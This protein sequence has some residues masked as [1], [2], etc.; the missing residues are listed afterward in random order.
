M[1]GD[2]VGAAAVIGGGI[3]GI[4]SALDLA[5]SGIKVYLI[6]SGPSIGGTMSQLDK[7]FPTMD[8]A[9]CTLSPKLV[10]AERHPNIE[11]MTYCDL[12]GISGEEG[13][14]TVTVNKKARYV[15][16]TKCIGCEICFAK[17]PVKVPDEYNELLG[18]HKAIY[19]PF[20]QAVPKIAVIDAERCL[21]LTKGKCGNCAKACEAGAIDYEQKDKQ[22]DIPVGAIILTTGFK[23]FDAAKLEQYHVE[24]TKVI[25]SMQFERMLSSS[26]PT[27]GHIELMDG[28]RPKR[29]AWIQ[30][31]GSRNPEIGN[32]YCSAV[33]CMYATKEAMVAKEHD[34]TLDMTIFVIDVRAFG[35]G[36]EEFYQRAKTAGVRYIRSRP[37]GVDIDP[38]TDNVYIKY[39]SEEGA[40]E[41]EEFDVIVLS[42]GLTASEETKKIAEMA[43]IE[44]DE[45][46]N[47]KTDLINPVETSVP[48]IFASGTIQ[49]PKD[50]PDT[51]ADASG[52]AAKAGA[53]LAGARG[54]LVTKK[55]YPDEIPLNGDKPRIGVV[56]CRCGINIGNVVDVPDV[57]EYASALPGVVVSK[58]EIYACSGDSHERIG[59]MIKEHNLNRVVVASCTPRTHEPLFQ[60]TCRNAGLNPFLFELANIREH[61][62][63]VHQNEPEKATVK[64][65]DTVRIAVAKSSL[66]EPLYTQ[67]LSLIKSALVVG[68]GI[69]GMTAA[70]DIANNGFEVALVE[71]EPELGGM[72]RSIKNLHNGQ[73]ASVVLSEMVAKVEASPLV[74]AYTGTMLES[75]SGAMGNFKAT[76]TGGTELEFG[77]VIIATGAHEFEPEGYFSYGKYENVVTQLQLEEMLEKSLDADIKTVV[78]IQCAG[79]RNDERP[80]C[81]R[82]CCINA[83]KNAIRIKEESPDT[84]IYVLYRDIRTYGVWEELY[85]KARELGVFF[86]RYTEDQEPEVGDGVVNVFDH[87]LGRDVE[88]ATELVVLS[89]PTETPESN[90]A[91]SEQFKVPLG[92]N[93]FFLEAHIK[94]R[95]VDFATDGVF[96]CGAAQSPKL[97]DESVAQASAAASRACTILTRDTLETMGNISVVDPERCIGC[98][99]CVTVCP[100][101]APTMQDVT[102][103]VEEITYTAKKSEINPT[104]CKG[105]GSCASACPANAITARHFTVGMMLKSVRAF[106]DIADASEA[107]E[108]TA[109]GETAA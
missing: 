28:S 53:M 69:A 82:V 90:V 46:G 72:L 47:I 84:N 32:P 62:S 98:G 36:F 93:N 95:P 8:C 20:P 109:A 1:A 99:T 105:C 64:A 61:C 66:A 22:V 19:L 68:G 31:V 17:C 44:L 3:A 76:L 25:T 48:G 59:E 85:I 34:P 21:Y 50:I 94:L 77:A 4:Q 100:Y 80:Y 7:T 9:M 54:T 37:N 45:F 57:V 40:I 56:V 39:E 55:E 108:G 5:E 24:H 87:L 2:K 38:V 78:M 33:C 71:M 92:G 16:E 106:S 96:L 35:K 74:T 6:E 58:E 103:T 15:D 29:I 67:E 14:F 13:N 52:A 41:R 73:K 70:L 49:G 102:V 12:V 18:K 104:L 75:V 91:L 97:I 63:W 10:D 79:G 65:K 26:G 51:V 83:L 86:M 81:S 23:P 107:G 60:E 89:A 88:I 30:C 11:L 43:G 101:E 42:I 27:E